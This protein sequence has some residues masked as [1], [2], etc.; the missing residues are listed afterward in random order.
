MAKKKQEILFIIYSDGNE[1]IVTTPSLEKKAIK[2]WFKDTGR[3]IEDFQ[4]IESISEGISIDTD[5]NMNV[6]W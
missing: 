3:D 4:R 2:L 1:V 5:V 6:N